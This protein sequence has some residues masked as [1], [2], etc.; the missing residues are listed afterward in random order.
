MSDVIYI[1][2]LRGINLAGRNMVS[3]AELRAMFE[4][5][6]FPNARSLL[7]SGNV[8]FSCTGTTTAKL[9]RFLEAETHNCFNLPVQ[10]YVRTMTDLKKALRANPFKREAM[11]AP[12]YLYLFFLKDA[13]TPD[14]VRKLR[15]AIPADESVKVNGKV[16]YVRYPEGMGRS[17]LG[18]TVI[19]RRLETRATARNWNTVSKLV[20]LAEEL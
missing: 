13:P 14:S 17:K 7:Q 19:E 16:A 9:E 18:S 5:V 4:R 2:L 11:H 1:A 3:M 8:V 10:Y 12:S 20:R 15:A 6:G